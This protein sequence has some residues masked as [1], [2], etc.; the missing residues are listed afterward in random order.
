MTRPP[1]RVF[2]TRR[3]HVILRQLTEE[4]NDHRAAAWSDIWPK[5]GRTIEAL[6]CYAYSSRKWRSAEAM[7]LTVG[8][9]ASVR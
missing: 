1:F 6:V 4:P 5:Q 9:I 2:Y 8:K 7:S 3:L